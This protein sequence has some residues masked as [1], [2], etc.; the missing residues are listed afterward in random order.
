MGNKFNAILNWVGRKPFDAVGIAFFMLGIFT[1]MRIAILGAILFVATN[2]KRRDVI[3]A[4]AKEY[5]ITAGLVFTLVLYAFVHSGW[6]LA[7]GVVG[8]VAYL[9]HKNSLW[10]PAGK[11]SLSLGKTASKGTGKVLA[12]CWEHS[13]TW[14]K[15]L[16]VGTALIALAVVLQMFGLKGPAVLVGALGAIIGGIPIYNLIQGIGKF[17]YS[18][19][20]KASPPK[21]E[22][23]GEDVEFNAF[24]ERMKKMAEKE[25]KEKEKK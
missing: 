11:A 15:M 2:T 16:I 7:I 8:C 5:P 4:L 12:S 25:R 22:K 19:A 24:L 23:K 6:I 14:A 1:D 10:A 17:G 18:I 21:K 9:M 3:I 13:P 20:S